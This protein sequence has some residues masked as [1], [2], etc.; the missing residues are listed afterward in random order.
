MRYPVALLLAVL[1]AGC[2][3]PTI[4]EVLDQ[5]QSEVNTRTLEA[6]GHRMEIR[7]VSRTAQVLAGSGLDGSIRVSGRLIDSLKSGYGGPEGLTFLLR[8]SP[9]DSSKN[10]GFDHDVVYG[11]I[12]GFGNYKETLQEY[13]FG[14]T[15][16]IWLELDGTRI[17]LSNYQMENSFGVSRSRTFTLLFPELPQKYRGREAHVKIVLDDIVPGLARKKLDWTLTAGKND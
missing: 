10:I 11:N 6:G 4:R 9:K 2:K 8:L 15:K 17:P 1:F 14:L 3:Q 16:K 7:Y 5:A 13:A 12:S